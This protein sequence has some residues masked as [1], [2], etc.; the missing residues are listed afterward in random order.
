MIVQS[1]IRWL[2]LVLAIVILWWQFT[3]AAI[4][5]C[6]FF[7]AKADNPLHNASSKVVIAH[8]GDR[9][10]FMMANNFQGDVKEFAR[11]VPI[12]VVP[13][14]EQVRI[15]NNEIIEQLDTYTAPRLAQYID[16]PCQR[17]KDFL[18]KLLINFVVFAALG[19]LGYLI[20]RRKWKRVI[21]LIVIYFFIVTTIMILLIPIITPSYFMQASK[22]NSIYSAQSASTV[23]VEDQFTVGEY[24]IVILSAQQSNDLVKWLQQNQYNI[25][26]NAQQMLQSYINEGMKF[27]VTRVNLE[28]F[29]QQGYRYLRPIVLDY[30]SPKFMLPIRLGTL[31]AIGDQDLT[32]FILSPNAYI[33]T[34]N[35]RTATIPTDAKSTQAQLS[36]EEL[37][38]FIQDEFSQFYSAVFDKAH[39]KQ[40]KNAVFL[41]YA[42]SFQGGTIGDISKVSGNT[43]RFSQ[44]CDPCT[45]E[46]DTLSKMMEKIPETGVFWDDPNQSYIT[47]L[48]LRY[49]AQTFPKDL[50]FQEITPEKLTQQVK[51][52]G[53]LF[54]NQAGVI[55][56][57]RY[58]IR[59]S[60]DTDC[61]SG[62]RYQNFKQRYIF[63][64]LAQLTGWNINTIKQKEKVNQRDPWG[65]T[66]LHNTQSASE[67]AQLIAQ[68]A[69]VNAKGVR[70]GM[71]PL[72]YAVGSDNIALAQVLIK[73][74]ADVNIQDTQQKTPLF[75]A[76]TEP[77]KKLLINHGADINGGQS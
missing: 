4:A 26:N 39:E 75:Y 33:E 34:V 51:Q 64:N 7:V 66:P 58:V 47:R 54:P 55:F 60:N 12:P 46:P 44:K 21:W 68:G 27:F 32:I 73:N 50:Y 31:N 76:K 19:L 61:F 70:R 11:I 2:K 15:G 65:L 13:T 16:N 56:Q 14:R 41:E 74:G 52:E 67:A 49:N 23:T 10:V 25:P 77:M 3:P 53:K 42:G 63:N 43:S 8:S 35:Y 5:F 6:G 71:T 45:M 37:P 40:G 29:Q 30:Q 59:H 1:G 18:I 57:G 24:D 36:G 20:Y 17:E 62:K 72:H 38:E 48:H 69:S 28:N 9:S 22:L